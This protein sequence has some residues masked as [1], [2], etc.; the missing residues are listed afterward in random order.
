[1]GRVII[2]QTLST[3]ATELSYVHVTLRNNKG[4]TLDCES[5][6]PT[7][8]EPMQVIPKMLEK[9]FPPQELARFEKARS[10]IWTAT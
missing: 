1:M 8:I 6:E 9:R 2:L 3:K 4:A 7:I 5:S 10:S